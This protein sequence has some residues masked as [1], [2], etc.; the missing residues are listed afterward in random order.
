M[1]IAQMINEQCQVIGAL[2]HQAQQAQTL[3]K[4]KA[5]A[6]EKD[7]ENE[8]L[9][10][11]LKAA[12]DAYDT[13]NA[14]LKKAEQKLE[15]LRDIEKASGQRAAQGE[16]VTENGPAYIRNTKQK[17]EPKSLIF[18]GAAVKFLAH[19]NQ[20]PVESV[21]EKLLGKDDGFKA[22]WCLTQKSAVAPANTF[23]AG[24]AQ[25]LTREAVGQLLES[26]ENVS[27]AAAL[28]T[29]GQVL[30]FDGASTLKVPR[31][32][33]RSGQTEPAWVGEGGAIPLAKFSFGSETLYR[34]KLAAIVPATEEL[35]QQSFTNIVAL[36]QREMEKDYS[37]KL[38]AGFLSSAAAV[39][40]VRPA[41][42]LNGYSALTPTAGGGIDAVVGDITKL[43]TVLAGSNMGE[44]P[45]LVINKADEVAAAAMRNDLGQFQFQQ[46][47]ANGRLMG[48]PYVASNSVP[49]HTLMLID[50][51]ALATA[52]DAPEYMVSREAT[53]VEA[54]ADGSAPT[55]A[56]DGSGDLG[57]A[58][59][60]PRDGGIA[61]SAAGA[62]TADAGF[63]VRSLFQTY[64]LAVRGIFP[65]TFA[66]LR[67]NM[68]AYMTATTW[69][70]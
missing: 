68:L 53:L 59:E 70:S 32:N 56:D 29:Y 55:H 65:T 9:R 14:E 48:F 46:E 69:T 12:S 42:I 45:V 21:I 54:N 5:E 36:F 19:M 34:H 35:A 61:P 38:D 62:G 25:E 16:P 44:R 2:K 64:S 43:A 1:N 39:P 28:A 15:S 22:Y 31:V 20:V 47:M 66:R 58:G 33:Q 27:I 17:E 60:V 13:Q 67:P 3:M 30:N 49:Q 37:A 18:K 24:W 63:T 7:L 10:G 57:T 6:L 41:G 50:A 26:I 8:D 40:G 4:Q 23:T 52:L 11:E 51:A